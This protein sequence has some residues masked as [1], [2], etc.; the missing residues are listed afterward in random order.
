MSGIITVLFILT[1]S[2]ASTAD[3]VSSD[4]ITG[5]V[6]PEIIITAEPMNKSERIGSEGI[7]YDEAYGWMLPT[8]VITAD[9]YCPAPDLRVT[10]WFLPRLAFGQPQSQDEF[11]TTVSE[12]KMK[13]NLSADNRV[14]AMSFGGNYTLKAGDTIRDD[15]NVSGG[16]ANING[17]IIGD[18]A[19]MGGEAFATG[20]VDGDVAVL[21]GNLY[22][23][24]SIT[25]DAAV[26]GGK[27][28][29]Q[30]VIE[31][32]VFIVG[33]EIKLDS[34][35]V[36]KGTLGMIGGSVDQDSLAVIQG[37]VKSIG[38]EQLRHFMPRIFKA[39]RLGPH[40]HGL[41]IVSLMFGFAALVILF[42]LNLLIL[43]VFPGAVNQINQQIQF[44]TWLAVALGV[45]VMILYLPVLLLFVVSIIGIPL[46]PLFILA[47][48]VALLFGLASL[49]GIVG[50]KI[51]QGL[52]L[53][54]QGRIGQF[55]IGWLALNLIP[56]LGLLLLRTGFLGL[57]IF[58]FGVTIIFVVKIIALG[59]VILALFHKNIEG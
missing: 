7:Y 23:T 34:G 45:A 56:A 33:G 1:Q 14:A 41:R 30:G 32:D 43:A 42:L 2:F 44:K 16:T 47:T 46:I 39:W 8:T 12:N 15:V 29:H 3:A 48:G 54:I 5:Y 24:G 59:A 20:T 38:N 35:S 36:I 51:S 55:A 18:L 40:L 53:K 9:R 57:L 58:L 50:E 52:N 4:S 11:L 22:I 25:G 10:D 27:I 37:E 31:G 19:V 13:N 49:S 28:R 6:L 17:V 26:M 21:G